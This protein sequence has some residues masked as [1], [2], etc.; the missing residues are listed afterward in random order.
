MF[1]RL[2]L[3]VVL[4][5][6]IVPGFLLA[7]TDAWADLITFNFQA[8]VTSVA[9][10]LEVE[11]AFAVGQTISGSYTFNSATGDSSGAGDANHGIFDGA[12]TALSF[13]VNG[14][15]GS[16]GVGVNQITVGLTGGDADLYQVENRP[17]SGANVG[18]DSPPEG[19]ILT[20]STSAADVFATD[21]LLL[22][23]PD[24][25]L[26]STHEIVLQ[27]EDGDVVA[28]LT[29]LTLVG[30]PAAVPGPSPLLVV[31]LGGLALAAGSWRGR[32]R[33]N[34]KG[35]IALDRLMRED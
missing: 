9:T 5:S 15:S 17:F 12:L 13:T 2:M 8:I 26:F 25:S 22:T 31:T 34:R 28:N 3:C 33:G 16:L 18:D 21:A 35:P 1:R 10:D 6:A 30:G 7:V 14:Y 24:L 19:F 29:S 27:F 4:L 20:V 32:D 11:G 23:P